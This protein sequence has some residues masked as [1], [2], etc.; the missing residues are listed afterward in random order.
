MWAGKIIA[1]MMA[2]RYGLGCGW[3]WLGKN[4]IFKIISVAYLLFGALSLGG[5]GADVDWFVSFHGGEIQQD[6]LVVII[7]SAHS[8]PLDKVVLVEG[9]IPPGMELQADGTV[10]G[11]P[12]QGGTYDFTLELTEKNGKVL[13][14]AYSV[15]IEPPAEGAE[16]P[17]KNL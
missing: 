6:G 12:E 9:E 3:A 10:Q 7:G 16:A 15:E 4:K 17:S 1:T 5:C 13:R 8:E 11:V 14:K 2:L